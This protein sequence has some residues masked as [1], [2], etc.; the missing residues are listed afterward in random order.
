MLTR[1][2]E[3]VLMNHLQST[4]KK[5]NITPSSLEAIA[6]SNKVYRA[7]CHQAVDNFE[8]NRTCA[9][10]R[11]QR[12]H[13]RPKRRPLQPGFVFYAPLVDKVV[14]L[15]SASATINEATDGATYRRKSSSTLMD[16]KTER[17]SYWKL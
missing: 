16:F 9:F 14:P 15:T 2:A 5:C 4:L 6:A 7:T 17:T 13:V 12:R 11:C 10:E 8:L 3:N 1:W